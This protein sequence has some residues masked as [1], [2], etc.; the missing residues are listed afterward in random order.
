MCHVLWTHTHMHLDLMYFRYIVYCIII[1]VDGFVCVCVYP[2][3]PPPS[4]ANYTLIIRSANHPRPR[5]SRRLTTIMKYYNILYYI[6]HNIIYLH[7]ERLVRGWT[8]RPSRVR[9]RAQV[10]RPSVRVRPSHPPRD[11]T[12]PRFIFPSL[13]IGIYTALY[14]FFLLLLFRN[15]NQTKPRRLSRKVICNRF[16][17]EISCSREPLCTQRRRAIW[18]LLYFIECCAARGGGHNARNTPA[19]ITPNIILCALYPE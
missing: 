2:S 1:W 17:N 13:Y 6:E 10:H 8:S 18:K 3:P 5:V 9:A 11:D 16:P 4:P 12:S 19:T 7:V 15:E 14:F